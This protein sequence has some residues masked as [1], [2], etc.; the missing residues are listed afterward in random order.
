MPKLTRRDH[1]GARGVVLLLHGGKSQSRRPVTALSASWLR[2]ALLQ[3]DL[4]APLREEGLAIW[5]LRYDVVG[6]NDGAE[7]PVADALWALDR[8]RE[9]YDDAPVVLLGH[10]MGARTATHVA[11]DPSVAGV[12]ALAPWF[13]QHDPVGGLAGRPLIALQGSHDRVTSVQETRTFV[14]RAERAGSPVRFVDMGPLGHYLLRRRARWNAEIL[15]AVL[16]LA[17]ARV[18]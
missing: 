9:V 2:A 11:G 4:H 16:E 15:T 7:S 18:D 17:P 14:E 12:V 8:I 13:P 1:V 3:R 5:L 10:S 6:W